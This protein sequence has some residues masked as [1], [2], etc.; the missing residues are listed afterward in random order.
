MKIPR[1][2][3]SLRRRHSEQASVYS[4]TL[5]QYHTRYVVATATQEMGA[6]L[7]LSVNLRNRSEDKM[8]NLFPDKGLQEALNH[9]LQQIGLLTGLTVPT[10][11]IE[12]LQKPNVLGGY[13]L[14]LN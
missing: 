8:A 10:G 6:K 13:T 3:A 11:V 1:R 2:G 5:F 14:I 7:P 12:L 4:V 9:T